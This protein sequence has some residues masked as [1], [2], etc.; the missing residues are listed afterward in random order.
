MDNYNQNK[1]LKSLNY[2]TQAQYLKEQKNNYFTRK[3]TIR[4]ES[5]GMALYALQQQLKCAG[6]DVSGWGKGSAKTLEHLQR[7]IESGE[8]VL[9]TD[10]QGRLLRKVE[11][12]SGNIFYIS[13]DGKRYRLREYEQVFK[14]GRKR[15]RNLGEAVSEKMKPNEDPIDAMIRGVREELGIEGKISLTETGVDKQLLSSPSYPGLQSQYI[16]HMFEV[17]LNDQQFRPDGYVEE[18]DDKNTYF[19]WE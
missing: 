6:I 10:K 12:V 19:I 9:I 15:T 3:N 5:R 18:Q 17:I 11:V 2:K 14:D 1:R 16:R 13:P 7:E 4:E 8:T